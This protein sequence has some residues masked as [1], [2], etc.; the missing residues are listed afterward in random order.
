[1]LKVRQR[2]TAF[3]RRQG[4]HAMNYQHDQSRILNRGSEAERNYFRC[5]RYFTVGHEWYATT[6]EG[7]DVGPCATRRQAE[8]TLA[9]HLADEVIKVPG[10]MG[11]IVAHRDRDATELEVLVQE[12]ANC[13]QHSLLRSE[14]GAYVWAQQRLTKFEEYPAEHDHAQI[15]ASALRYFLSELDA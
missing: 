15:R 9:R 2:K 1:M 11:Q 4:Q 8:M 5:G 14:N 10:Q 7:H 13:R 12:L 3:G 6:R